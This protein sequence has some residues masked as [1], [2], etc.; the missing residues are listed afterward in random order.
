MFNMER[1][2]EAISKLDQYNLLIHIFKIKQKTSLA[3]FKIWL[4]IDHLS[5]YDCSIS[6]KTPAQSLGC[7][8]MTGFPWAPIL[9]SGDKHRIFFAFKSLTASLMSLTSIQTWWIPP[10]AFF[11]K[12]PA[13]GDFSPR[14]CNSSILVFSRLTNTTVTPCSGKSSGSLYKRTFEI[15]DLGTILR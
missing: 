2:L 14:G 5:F 10:F 13:M 12:N 11:C 4:A 9:G 15:V 3:K 1:T 8:N 7:K 6:T